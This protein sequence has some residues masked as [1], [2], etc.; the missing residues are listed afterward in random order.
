MPDLYM[1][2]DD[3]TGLQGLAIAKSRTRVNKIS[4]S[5]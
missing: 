1:D 3:Y 2:R 5:S 4:F